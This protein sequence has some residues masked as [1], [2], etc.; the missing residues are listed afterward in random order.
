MQHCNRELS[1]YED[2]MAFQ[3][4]IFIV[5]F[6]PAL[7]L[8]NNLC[9]T[10]L[11]SLND[12]VGKFV[13]PENFRIVP[14]ILVHAFHFYRKYINN[15]MV[16]FTIGFSKSNKLN[17]FLE[18]FG[19]NI[20]GMS[21]QSVS[22]EFTTNNLLSYNGYL[23]H[24]L[25]L[26]ADNNNMVF[27][28]NLMDLVR[29]TRDSILSSS[30]FQ[31]SQYSSQSKMENIQ[32][33]YARVK[34]LN[35]LA[36]VNVELNNKNDRM[37]Q[38]ISSYNNNDKLK[39][40]EN[41]KCDDNYDGGDNENIKK[42][43]RQKKAFRDMKDDIYKSKILK[44]IE[45]LLIPKVREV[46][47]TE[48]STNFGYNELSDVAVIMTALLKRKTFEKITEEFK[49]VGGINNNVDH[50]MDVDESDEEE[51]DDI[52]VNQLPFVVRNNIWRS[53]VI[54][55]TDDNNDDHD[56]SEDIND[57]NSFLPDKNDLG[58]CYYEKNSIE[59]INMK[60]KNEDAF[61][62]QF[63]CLNIKE[64]ISAVYKEKIIFCLEDKIK[65]INIYKSEFDFWENQSLLNMEDIADENKYCCT[66]ITQTLL[67]LSSIPKY[68][69]ITRRQLLKW[70]QSDDDESL[71][72]KLKT[73]KKV[74]Q[75]FEEEVWESLL[76]V[77][78]E[79]KY[80]EI[81]HNTTFDL[82][83]KDNV[84]YTHDI[85]RI[86]ALIVQKKDE[87]RDVNDVSKLKFT[88]GW[89]QGFLK[90]NKFSRKKITRDAKNVPSA[91]VINEVINDHC[92]D[93]D[94]DV[95]EWGDEDDED[96]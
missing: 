87:W 56:S 12:D 65:I 9:D 89:I 16:G 32:I 55:D 75:A 96:E 80:S 61:L 58:D 45:F 13:Y 37:E 82:I 88:A 35:E 29:K 51:D 44:D 46:I 50:L 33:F 17:P 72:N 25:I 26:A 59:E 76:T 42:R 90:R 94:D 70:L 62:D 86:A 78:F 64:K 77:Y 11:L 6:N 63:T 54:Y 41:E 68:Q 1:S 83:I 30:K 10:D 14:F 81:D 34:Q 85:I 92:N 84:A 67:H 36:K 48:I 23:E 24:E 74:Y 21:T 19:P 57:E 49:E 31:L 8:K 66:A 93:D 53:R 40:N 91:E 15:K 20:N 3:L 2:Y 7:K 95:R 27:E 5:R 71:Y 47:F 4:A 28:T 69:S 52:R 39:Y 18:N 60:K 22:M 38:E 73:G 79:E 43:K